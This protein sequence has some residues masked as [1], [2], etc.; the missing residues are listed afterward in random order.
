MN[1]GYTDEMVQ[2]SFVLVGE[3]SGFRFQKGYRVCSW[4]VQCP[5][6]THV[7]TACSE[8][9]SGEKK[10]TVGLHQLLYL[11]AEVLP[12][13]VRMLSDDEPSA[14]PATRNQKVASCQLLRCGIRHGAQAD[15]QAFRPKVH[16]YF[17]GISGRFSF[18]AVIEDNGFF[19]VGYVTIY[20]FHLLSLLF[21]NKY[22]EEWVIFLYLQNS[23]FR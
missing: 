19:T 1:K 10:R 2:L 18:V 23:F 8:S 13:P 3:A 14:G 16:G 11:S 20:L 17:A 5:F 12:L 9:V 15:I 22:M 4:N 21:S 6:H 7:H